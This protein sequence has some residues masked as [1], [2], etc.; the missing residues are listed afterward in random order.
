MQNLARSLRPRVQ[1]LIPIAIAK[2]VWVFF[3][4]DFSFDFKFEFEFDVD[5][6]GF[7][8]AKQKVVLPVFFSV[9]YFCFFF[10][11]L[12]PF[13]L[14]AVY[15]VDVFVVAVCSDFFCFPLYCSLFFSVCLPW[16]LRRI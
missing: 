5:V 16:Y 11:F 1:V 10:C 15:V 3:L 12:G 6:C 4:S 2:A 9:L 7:L 13:F 8:S 14:F